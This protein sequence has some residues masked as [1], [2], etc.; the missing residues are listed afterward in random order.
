MRT[1]SAAGIVLIAEI[2]LIAEITG[3]I[4]LGLGFYGQT[5]PDFTERQGSSL[6]CGSP[7]FDSPPVQPRP[8]AV[9][10]LETF[11]ASTS[12]LIVCI[13]DW[14]DWRRPYFLFSKVMT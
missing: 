12:T 4:G 2:I 8:K 7:V 14:G 3:I 5:T 11:P 13:G 6:S 10:Y 1:L 9:I